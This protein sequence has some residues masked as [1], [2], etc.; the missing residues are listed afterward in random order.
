MGKNKNKNKNE[1]QSQTVQQP[2]PTTTPINNNVIQTQYEVSMTA[3]PTAEYERLINENKELNKLILKLN[4]DTLRFKETIKMHE[5][6]IEEL[7]MINEKL[8]EEIIE[9]KK[10]NSELKQINEQV[11]NKF[12]EIKK[13]HAE[14]KKENAEIKKENIKIKKENIEI[15]NELSDI[16]KQHEIKKL[17]IAI[18]DC[19]K[20]LNLRTS[21]NSTDLQAINDLNDE[22]IDNY[23]FINKKKC[24]SGDIQ[25][26]L[27]FI[28]NKIVHLQ[29][30]DIELY[31]EFDSLH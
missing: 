14:I 8:R 9:L 18:Q 15:K 30:N 16:K 27:I 6:T 23:H 17:R 26:K 1:Q 22:R 20:E 10:E 21:L 11:M 31:N 24:S 19:N 29:K 13:E 28:H 5:Q 3:L 12:A 4:G 7:K 25:N 2:V